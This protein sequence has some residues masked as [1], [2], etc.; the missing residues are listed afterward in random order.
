LEVA[1]CKNEGI[2]NFEELGLGP[3]M[4]HPLVLHYFSMKPDAS[5]EVFKI[6]SEEI[7]LLLSEF[8]D[9][10]QKKVIIVD[11]FLHFLS[12]NYPVKGPEMLGVRVQSLGCVFMNYFQFLS[13][14]IF[15]I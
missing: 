15:S 14:C 11:E 3:L 7:I 4:R 6:T 1:I 2:E 8:M 12:K 10:C 5:A 9:T 13:F